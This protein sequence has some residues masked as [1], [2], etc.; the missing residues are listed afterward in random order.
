MPIKNDFELQAIFNKHF[1]INY[2]RYYTTM[3]LFFG[4]KI[5]Q[6]PKNNNNI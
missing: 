2:R 6:S 1:I 3:K 4:A 5:Y